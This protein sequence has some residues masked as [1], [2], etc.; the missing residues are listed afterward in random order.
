[1][2]ADELKETIYEDL[3]YLRDWTNDQMRELPRVLKERGRLLELNLK[4]NSLVQEN[5]LLNILNEK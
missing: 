4:V 2:D 1:M 5:S 3:K